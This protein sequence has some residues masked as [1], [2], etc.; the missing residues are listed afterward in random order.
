MHLVQLFL[1]VRDNDGNAFPAA[2]F[3]NIRQELTKAFGGLTAFTR[4]PAEGLWTDSKNA[5]SSDDIV[6]F[7]VMLKQLD[8]PWWRA[9]KQLLEQIF[10]Q[11][12]IIIRVQDIR[13]I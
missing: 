8:E 2:H 11:D 6:I 9:Y 5:I 13:L 10:S 7:E 4:A 12:E 3:L 1:P